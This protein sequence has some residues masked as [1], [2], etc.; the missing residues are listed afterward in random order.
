MPVPTPQTPKAEPATPPATPAKENSATLPTG[1]TRDVRFSLVSRPITQGLSGK[2]SPAAPSTP[3]AEPPAASEDIAEDSTAAAPKQPAAAKE[4]P[5]VVVAIQAGGLMIACEDTEALDEF[6]DLLNFFAGNTMT[7]GSDM[8]IFYLKHTKASVAAEILDQVFG[9]GTLS[10][11]NAGGGGGGGLMG[12]LANAALGDAGG[13]LLGSLMGIG[14]GGGT[15]TPSGT[16]RITPDT[17]LNALIVQANPIDLGLI[18]QLLEIIDQK[19]P[20]DEILAIPRAKLIPLVNTRAD[21][22]A[23][24]LQE[25]YRD[26]MTSGSTGAQSGRPSPQEFMRQMMGVRSGRGGRGGSSRGATEQVQKMSL[27]VD[28]RTNSLIVAAPEPLLKEVTDLIA[29]L[30]RAAVESPTEVTRVIK[31]RRAGSESVQQALSVLTG[32]SIRTSRPSSGTTRS[33]PTTSSSPAPSSYR[34]PTSS[35]RRSS[36]TPQPPSGSVRPSTGSS[37]PSGGSAR[38][39]GGS[40][41]PSSG[42]SRPGG[43]TSSSRP[44]SRPP[45]SSRRGR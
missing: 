9:G 7:G 5:P 13:G 19:G 43:S 27:S 8:T 28:T 41:R 38:P 21:E 37:R 12:D 36:R 30:D 23:T 2:P 33:Q 35:F 20:P 24:V 31:L 25:V 15:I 44:G 34:P 32:E 14:G 3:V 22:I 42:F 18:E 29:Q 11:S 45:S 16:L 39:S 40:S 10:T 17:R 1:A 26:R 6:E 4:P